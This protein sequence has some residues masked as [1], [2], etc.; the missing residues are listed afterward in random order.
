MKTYLRSRRAG[1]L[2]LALLVVSLCPARA[3]FVAPPTF[4]TPI[5]VSSN[6]FIP[7][8]TLTN[9]PTTLANLIAVGK[10]GV[11]FA[12][13][14]G[15]TNAASTTN[16]T[17]VLEQLANGTDVVDSHTFSL[18]VPQNG[19]TGY[20]YYTNIQATAANFANATYVRVRSIQ[21]TNV[22]GIFITNF[23]ATTLQ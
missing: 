18:S 15:A 7:G 12:L 2:G 22:F 13:K 4:Q 5:T 3:Q 17:I 10:N 1:L 16:A 20:D 11:G 6:F 19:T 8:A 14:M 9:I 23:T 21:N